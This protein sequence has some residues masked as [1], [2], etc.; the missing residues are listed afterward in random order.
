M[1]AFMVCIRQDFWVGGGRSWWGTATVSC[2]SMRLHTNFFWGGGRWGGRGCGE[3]R[4][5]GKGEFQGHHP[6]Y[7]PCALIISTIKFRCTDYYG[8]VGEL[9]T[10]SVGRGRERRGIEWNIEYIVFKLRAK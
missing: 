1:Y 9:C 4:G 6:L 10:A 3:D 7:E 2:M 5:W 8:A